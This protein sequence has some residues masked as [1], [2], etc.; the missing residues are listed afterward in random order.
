MDARSDAAVRVA[1]RPLSA[2]PAFWNAFYATLGAVA[3]LGRALKNRRAAAKLDNLSDHELSDIGL[4]RDDLRFGRSMPLSM[5]PTVEYASRA[6]RNAVIRR[7][8]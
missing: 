5:D 8:Y 2:G 6:R 3:A 7:Y 1:A 4:T